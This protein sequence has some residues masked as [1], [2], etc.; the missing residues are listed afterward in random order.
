LIYIFAPTLFAWFI[1]NAIYHIK[2]FGMKDFWKYRQVVKTKNLRPGQVLEEDHF[3]HG[4]TPDKIKELQNKFDEVSIKN[5]YSF[6]PT[7]F[8]SMVIY[9][10]WL[11]YFA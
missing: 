8:I 6:I 2:K 1:I 10:I 7:I 4:L 11:Y 3:M 9:I 5:P